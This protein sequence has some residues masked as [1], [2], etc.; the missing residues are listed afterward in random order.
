MKKSKVKAGKKVLA[1]LGTK[2][3]L[4]KMVPLIRELSKRRIHAKILLTGQHRLDSEIAESKLGSSILGVFDKSA[5]GRGRFD[6]KA[7]ALLWVAR[8]TVWLFSEIRMERPSLVIVHGDTMSTFA[9]SIAAKAAGRKI[10]HV[11]AGLRSGSSREP[12]PEELS[13]R[14]ADSVSEYYF[15]PT[16][17]AEQNL[18]S[19]GRPRRNIFVTGNTN[20]DSARE[21]LAVRREKRRPQKNKERIPNK[22][23]IIAKIHRHENVSDK[24]RLERFFRA[25]EDS[26]VK[27]LIILPEN[28]KRNALKA[29]L[30]IP[31]NALKR[32]FMSQSDFLKILS[33]STAILTDAGGETEE[34]CYLGIPCI[35]FRE[36]SE[37]QEAESSGAAAR[38]TDPEKIKELI[39]LARD[40]IWRVPKNAKETFGKGKAAIEIA[41][42][43]E[44]EILPKISS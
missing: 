18:L 11:E 10:G 20:I 26:P 27:V 13:R 30:S 43:I 12:F 39:N 33:K 31:K 16:W 17:Q 25:V 19:E 36:K 40:K 29:G 4:I 23:F 34:A 41:D 38:T 6:S 7:G 42:A 22:P 28:L 9:G 8:L 35:Q 15:C 14:F 2:A 21:K 24:G 32:E 3:E 44:N 5:K 1:I 37:R